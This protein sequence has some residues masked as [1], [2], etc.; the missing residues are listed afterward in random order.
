MMISPEVNNPHSV[1]SRFRRKRFA[2]IERLLNI[3]ISR[4]GSASIIDIGGR[5]EYW[6]LL[7][8]KI[9]D[10]VHIT[11][12]NFRS[13]LESGEHLKSDQTLNVS[14]REGDGCSL[15]GIGDSEF[16][17]SHSNS[18][19]E[20]V[21]SF[22]RMTM[23]ARESRRVGNAYYIQTPYLW[24]PIDPHYGVPFIHWLPGPTRAAIF[25]RFN[26]GYA[27]RKP[28]YLKALEAVEYT[29]I[30]DRT[31]MSKLFPDGKLAR[32][33][34]LLMTKSIIMTRDPTF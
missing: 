28:D 23:F 29:Q 15:D 25:N 22:Q 19:I 2:Q 18:T 30:V 14:Y 32:E 16:D 20:H 24:F 6:S 12:V 34:L 21:G 13:E 4:K 5:I 31:L 8:N 27:K 9:A 3:I 26:V 1:S 17:L 10:K 7:D 33:R 11:L